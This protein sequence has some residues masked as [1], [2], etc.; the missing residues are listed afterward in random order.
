MV[1]KKLIKNKIYA[2]A[3]MVIGALSIPIERDVTFFIF[4]L[5]FGLPLFLTKANRFE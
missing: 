5:I 1:D 3:L 2:I 4:M